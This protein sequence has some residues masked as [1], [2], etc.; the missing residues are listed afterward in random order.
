M[1]MFCFKFPFYSNLFDPNTLSG[2]YMQWF[3]AMTSSAM[4]FILLITFAALYTGLC[5]YINGMVNDLKKQ[6]ENV[7]ETLKREAARP[8]IDKTEIWLKF[9]KEYQFHTEILE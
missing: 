5:F 7:D 1:T 8:R 9:V 6:V 2:Y 4:Y 3:I